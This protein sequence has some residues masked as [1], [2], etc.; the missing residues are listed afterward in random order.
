MM[1]FIFWVKLYCKPL[2]LSVVFG[3]PSRALLTILLLTGCLLLSACSSGSDSEATT[4]DGGIGAGPF[5]AQT[6]DF[7]GFCKWQSAP[8]TATGD[9]SDGV[10]ADAGPLTV[11]WNKSPPNG[12]HEF[13]VGTIVLK[14]SNQTDASK[15]IAFAM[16]KRQARGTDFN[17][18]GA[19]GWEW[20]SVQDLGN[21]NIERLWR[22]TAPPSG[23]SYT[24]TPGGD[25]NGC[26]VQAVANDYVWDDALQLSKF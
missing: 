17:A 21:C 9:A 5:I 23:E 12:A 4:V 10:H 14:E 13:P 16:V 2:S 7:A 18:G 22:G 25:C 1:N 19:D 8:A 26:H 20:W 24:N 6:G 3:M 11:Y 15:R